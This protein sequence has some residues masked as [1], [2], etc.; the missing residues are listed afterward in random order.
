MKFGDPKAPMPFDISCTKA[1]IGRWTDDKNWIYDFV[2][3]VPPGTR[4]TFALKPTF[5]L[6]SGA[7]V[8]GKIVFQF[9]TGGFA[10][11][12][13]HPSGGT[14]SMRSKSSLWYKTAHSPATASSNMYIAKPK[15]ST[16]GF[17]LRVISGPVRKAF[18][19]SLPTKSIPTS[20]APS[21]F[22][23]VYLTIA[24]RLILELER[25]TELVD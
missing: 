20:S 5:T 14:T 11:I 25:V 15:A 23:N 24:R 17:R 7:A 21:N 22:T 2:R 4:C 1:G 12:Y 10:V 16:S 9:N 13:T 3:D 8:S 18:S 19:K 6:L